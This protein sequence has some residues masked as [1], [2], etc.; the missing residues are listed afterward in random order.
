[1]RKQSMSFAAG[2]LVGAA[3]FGCGTA[4]AAGILA[5]RSTNPVYVDGK[6][7]QLEA[8][9]IN[10]NNYVK[11]RDIG[12]AVNFN[13]YWDGAVQV[14]SDAAYTGVTPSQNVTP[15]Q[16]VTTQPTVTQKAEQA[17][18]QKDWSLEANP[19]IFHG[20]YTREAYNV[21]RQA[22]VDQKGGSGYFNVNPENRQS[23]VNILSWIGE[24]NRYHLIHQ[25]NTNYT[26]TAEKPAIYADAVAAVSGMIAEIN[27]LPTD[28]DKV[29]YINNIICDK[30]T[31]E[32]DGV[33]SPHKVFVREG[34]FAG[35]C[36]DYSANFQFLCDLADIPCIIVCSLTHAWNMVYVDGAWL[37]VD[38]VANDVGDEIDSRNAVL[39][40]VD[41]ENSVRIDAYP[42]ITAFS[43]ELL[44]PGSTK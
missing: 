18:T 8:Y 14:D 32:S 17:T 39:L 6:L 24:A 41:G 16:S 10:G 11:L 37:Y 43:K 2:L 40:K 33:A 44:V 38:C 30:M 25:N 23:F 13:V 4:Y 29:R 42:D 12:Q 22:V 35:N 19:A 20:G 21:I 5:Q 34:V 31:Y 15:N 9:N 1:M 36:A 3:L 27:K 26:V 7:V 28:A